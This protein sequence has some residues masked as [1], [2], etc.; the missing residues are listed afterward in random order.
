MK[1][2]NLLKQTEE[3]VNETDIEHKNE[4]S[5][6]ELQQQ[7]LAVKKEVAQKVILRDQ[8]KRA[9]PFNPQALIETINIIA[10]L[11]RRQAQLIELQNEL[12]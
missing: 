5:H 3:Q 7:L 6:L 2:I 11:E 4:E 10:L 1:Y 12:F 9:Y 8:L